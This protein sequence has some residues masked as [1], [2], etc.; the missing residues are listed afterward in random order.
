MVTIPN[1]AFHI[2]AFQI[3]HSFEVFFASVPQDAEGHNNHFKLNL[4]ESRM[5]ILYFLEGAFAEIDTRILEQHY[6]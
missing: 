6:H 1:G 2:L 5:D 4:R 3:M